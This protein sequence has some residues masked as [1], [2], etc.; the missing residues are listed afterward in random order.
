MA[1]KYTILN[2][3]PESSGSENIKLQERAAMAIIFVR[4]RS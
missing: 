2:E 1:Y 4:T 3:H